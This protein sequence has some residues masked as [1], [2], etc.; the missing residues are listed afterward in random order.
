MAI[1][2]LDTP[3][4]SKFRDSYGSRYVIPEGDIHPCVYQHPRMY[5]FEICVMAQYLFCDGH[6]HC[7][8]SPLIYTN[9]S[10]HHCPSLYNFNLFH[11]PLEKF[12]AV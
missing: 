9:I 4:L 2:N 10:L 12:E 8:N 11:I 3:G 1:K 7:V 6:S 5:F